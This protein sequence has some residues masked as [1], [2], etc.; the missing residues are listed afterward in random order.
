M[1]LIHGVYHFW[2]K[3]VA[4]RNDYCLSCEAPR[5]SIAVRSF[6]VGHVYWVPLVPVGF[7]RHWSCSVCRRDPHANPKA[8][9]AFKWI[10]MVCLVLLSAMFWSV[11][12]NPDLEVLPWVLRIFPM[13]GAIA[14]FIQLMRTPIEPS[15]RERLAAI[16]PAVD[17]IC[18]FCSTPLCAG[19]IAAGSSRWLC[20][21]C[22]AE[23]Y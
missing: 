13:G 20:P 18:P 14:L 1:L 11:P 22:G 4:F 7:W 19:S 23:R 9:R 16:L 2:P 21:A 8:R 12:A 15:L 3:K 10:A 5:R 17:S 6:D